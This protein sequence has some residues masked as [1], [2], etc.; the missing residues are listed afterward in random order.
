MAAPDVRTA[1]TGPVDVTAGGPVAVT[2]SATNAGPGEARQVALTISQPGPTASTAQVGPLAPRAAASRAQA[3]TV[4]CTAADGTTLVS[5]ASVVA[6]GALGQ[7]DLNP[8]NDTASLTT[9]VRKPVPQL[10]LAAAPSGLAGEAVPV[11][12]TY[13]NAGSAPAT[14]VTARVVLPQD[15]YYAPRLDPTGSP[16]PSTVTRRAD[17]TTELGWTLPDLAVNAAAGTITFRVR[18]SLLMAPGTQVTFAGS[19]TTNAANGCPALVTAHSTSTIVTVPATAGT[20]VSTPVRSLTT[21]SWTAETL[22]RIQ[23]TD[24]RFDG[25]ANTAPDGGL[26]TAETRSIYGLNLS[27]QLQLR[28]ELLTTYFNLAERRF[29]NDTTLRL[30]VI[31][32]I[33][34]TPTTAGEAAHQA[35]QLLDAPS[36]DPIAAA[37]LLVVLVP[38]NSGLLT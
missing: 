18:P 1:L 8:A 26:D 34:T 37:K 9:T 16:R 23:A 2:A 17:G 20:P 4:P 7:E 33:L 11:T 30:Q 29:N 31:S 35:Q 6:T 25:A 15:V 21:A 24:Q 36:F 3:V 27:I 5:T 12:V 38:L 13:R 28:A 22:S 10:S 32:P 19:L 14:G